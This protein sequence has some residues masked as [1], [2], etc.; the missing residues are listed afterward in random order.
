MCGVA[1]V[2]SR[3]L[4]ARQRDGA[5]MMTFPPPRDWDVLV[6]GGGI[7]GAGILLEAARRGLKTL[8]VEQ[9]DFGCG[10]SSRSSKLMHGGLLDQ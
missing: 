1:P 3:R 2:R 8:L 10:T 6:I 9:A 4:H 5:A 7:T